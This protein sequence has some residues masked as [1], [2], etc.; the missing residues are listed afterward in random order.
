[1][2]DKS[3]FVEQIKHHC[4]T[5][6]FTRWSFDDPGYNC[7][8][9]IYL[10]KWKK[11]NKNKVPNKEN[12]WKFFFFFNPKEKLCPKF[13]SPKP[14]LPQ[15]TWIKFAVYSIHMCT[16][17][18]TIVR[19]VFIRGQFNLFFD[20]FLMFCFFFFCVV[21]LKLI[22]LKATKT[23]LSL[24]FFGQLIKVNFRGKEWNLLEKEGNV[25]WSNRA[26]IVW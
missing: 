20:P 14:N 2:I 4:W 21:K 12:W 18:S 11:K 24:F 25:L 19:D 8:Y 9:F 1:M 17:L 10:E 3:I 26:N 23:V 5:F 6:S 13:R 7:L 15:A 22:E 16:V